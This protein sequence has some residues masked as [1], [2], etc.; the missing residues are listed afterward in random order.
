MEI[1]GGASRF[2]YVAKP[3]KA[4]RNQGLEN[5][6]SKK[7]DVGRIDGNPSGDNP[8]N[9]GVN[10]TQ[11]FHPTVKPIRLMQYLVHMVTPL[12]G[13]CIDPFNGSGTTGIACG[14]EDIEY[15]G[16]D[17]E[18]DYIMISQA[19]ANSYKSEINNQLGLFDE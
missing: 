4:E 7:R 3:S 11:N 9:R 13:K 8:R 1:L 2:F 19:R 14:I 5:F 17:N 12:G 6:E 10:E 16:V 18:D 15:E